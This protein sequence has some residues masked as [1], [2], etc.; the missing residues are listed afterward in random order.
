M[1]RGDRVT[2][3]RAMVGVAILVRN[4]IIQQQMPTLNLLCLEAVAVLIRLNNLSVTLVSAVVCGM[5][6]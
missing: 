4:Q 3:I 5:C 2:Q 6:M 1:Y